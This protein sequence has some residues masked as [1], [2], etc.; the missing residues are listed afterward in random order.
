MR[1]KKS[2][3]QTAPVWKELAGMGRKVLRILGQNFH[4][5]RPLE[6]ERAEWT[7]YIKY[8]QEGMVVFDVGAYTGQLTLLFSKF[9]GAAGQI[10]AFEASNVAFNRLKSICELAGCKNATLNHMA[11]AEK[12]GM[13]RLHVYDNEHLSWSS[14]TDRPLQK[15]GVSAK[16]VGVEEVMATTIDAYCEKNRISCIDLL[17]IDVEGAEYQVL[18]GARHM[19]EDKRI[20][21]CVFEFGQATFDMGNEPNEIEAYLRCLGY[22][23]RNIVKGDP[24]FPRGSSPETACFSMHVA[25]PRK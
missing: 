2:K 3:A 8:L 14:L 7:F 11:V 9:V 4:S 25:S 10:H 16:S 23:I 6:V 21:C 5:A 22:Q 24:V 12:E 15:Y 20:L 17:K 18:L 19:L 1:S 13:V